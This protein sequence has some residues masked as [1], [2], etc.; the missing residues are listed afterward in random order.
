MYP[1]N[2]DIIFNYFVLTTM[3]LTAF[4]YNYF[5]LIPG[6]WRRS[7]PNGGRSP[8]VSAVLL[9]GR[10]PFCRG[11]HAAHWRRERPAAHRPDR[12]GQ[13]RTGQDRAGQG[14]LEKVQRSDKILQCTKS[15]ATSQPT[16]T[17]WFHDVRQAASIRGPPEIRAANCRGSTELIHTRFHYIQ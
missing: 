4:D 3:Q 10:P 9:S 11:C 13:G 6:E 8:T 1:T 16:R 7:V 17:E 2:L 15:P 5:I 12:A 14:R